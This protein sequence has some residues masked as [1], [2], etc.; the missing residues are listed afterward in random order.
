MQKVPQK[1]KIT[2]QITYSTRK[3]EDR[4]K[5]K[6]EGYINLGMVGWYCRRERVRREDDSI[7][8]FGTFPSEEQ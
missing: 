1:Q 2:S 4:R 5:K 6:S 3:N 8:T 7:P